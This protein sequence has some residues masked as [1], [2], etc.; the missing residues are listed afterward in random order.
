MK[1]ELGI[2]H[3]TQGEDQAE[4]KT[5]DGTVYHVH[6]GVLKKVLPS[7]HSRLTSKQRREIRKLLKDRS[8]PKV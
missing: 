6:K 4:T 1:E 3:E 2:I 8:K 7:A 5:A